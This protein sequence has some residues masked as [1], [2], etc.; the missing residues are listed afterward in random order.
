VRLLI[1]A[2]A[3]EY[4]DDG[5][6]ASSSNSSFSGGIDGPID[7]PI[8]G[9]VEDLC[10]ACSDIDSSEGFTLLESWS[11]FS[12]VGTGLG[13]FPSTSRQSHHERS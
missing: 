13:R 1:V 5:A 4:G 6:E 7:G 2:R 9:P 10:D 3:R 8:A 12:G 11:F